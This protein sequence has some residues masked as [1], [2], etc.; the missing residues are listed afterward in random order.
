MLS[1][2]KNLFF[3]S[4]LDSRLKHNNMVFKATNF[5]YHTL[6]FPPQS[7]IHTGIEHKKGYK[8]KRVLKIN[9]STLM[10]FKMGLNQRPPD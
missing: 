10:R 3:E 2:N 1:R 9:L 6:I 5:F 8:T 7:P 4:L